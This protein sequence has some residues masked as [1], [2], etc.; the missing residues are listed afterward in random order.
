M[1]QSPLHDSSLREHLINL[2]R[3]RNAHAM[4]DDVIED[5]P[6]EA[7]GVKPQ[8]PSARGTDPRRCPWD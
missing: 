6:A 1:P 4:F 8:G 2:L 3:A 5:F 7:R